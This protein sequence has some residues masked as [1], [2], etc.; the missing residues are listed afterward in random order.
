MKQQASVGPPVEMH[1]LQPILVTIAHQPRNDLLGSFVGPT[2]H[3]L[4]IAVRNGWALEILPFE[5]SQGEK[6]VK[7]LFGLGHNISKGWGSGFIDASSRK[8]YDPAKLNAM[9]Y[10]NLG[11][12]PKMPDPAPRNTSKWIDIDAKSGIPKPGPELRE[13]CKNKAI[14]GNGFL[15]CRLWFPPNFPG[16]EAHFLMSYIEQN[17]GGGRLF[18]PVF[19]PY[20]S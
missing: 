17:G 12:F 15:R 5:G 20:D 4:A 18:Q 7:F 11:F 3:L 8:D 10:D 19:S 13:M 14:P 2:L 6:A 16:Q 1:D 9:S